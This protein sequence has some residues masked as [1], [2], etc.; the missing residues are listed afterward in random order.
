MII[1]YWI[2][3]GDFRIYCIRFYRKK[4]LIIM[5]ISDF[6]FVSIEWYFKL[7]VWYWNLSIFIIVVEYDIK[8][9]NI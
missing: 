9:I 6:I 3:F 4:C 7:Y 8:I 2:V 1:E 5:K